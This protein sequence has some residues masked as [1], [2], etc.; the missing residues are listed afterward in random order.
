MFQRECLSYCF[1]SVTRYVLIFN[2][3][4]HKG[5]QGNLYSIASVISEEYKVVFK[6][7]I[8]TKSEYEAVAVLA[9][10]KEQ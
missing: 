10:D 6:R 8:K 5:R 3:K 7:S 4:S 9:Q 1:S 2:N